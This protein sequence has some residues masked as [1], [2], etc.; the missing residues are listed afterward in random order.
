LPEYSPAR[1]SKFVPFYEKAGCMED[2]AAGQGSAVNAGTKEANAPNGYDWP[3]FSSS[4]SFQAM[5]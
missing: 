2:V 5:H 1:K 4:P 3:C